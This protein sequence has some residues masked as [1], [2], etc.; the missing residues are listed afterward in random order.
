MPLKIRCEY[1]PENFVAYAFPSAAGPSKS[2]AMVIVG[3]VMMGPSESF[4]SRGSYCGS[5]LARLSLHR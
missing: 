3:T 4:C 2:L 5:P 1:L